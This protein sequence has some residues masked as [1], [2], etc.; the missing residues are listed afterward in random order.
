MEAFDYFRQFTWLSAVTFPFPSNS[1]LWVH[2]QTFLFCPFCLLAGLLW[3]GRG[4]VYNNTHWT[5]LVFLGDLPV[6]AEISQSLS[7]NPI[8]TASK[9]LHTMALSHPQT[10]LHTLHFSET[11]PCQSSDPACPWF[12]SANATWGLFLC[13]RV[14]Q[15]LSSRTLLP[16]WIRWHPWGGSCSD[17]QTSALTTVLGSFLGLVVHQRCSFWLSD[18][19]FW[20]QVRSWTWSTCGV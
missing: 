5:S 9:S 10:V 16:C 18:P 6:M 15:T 8:K 2:S 12:C 17:I 7:Q 14:L 20:P 19:F 13:S 3:L 1:Y 4:P 11:A